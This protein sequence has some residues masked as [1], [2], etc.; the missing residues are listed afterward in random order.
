LDLSNKTLTLDKDKAEN[1][2]NEKWAKSHSINAKPDFGGLITLRAPTTLFDG[3]FLSVVH[4]SNGGSSVLTREVPESDSDAPE[5]VRNS[6]PNLWVVRSLESVTIPL[7][8][9]K[10]FVLSL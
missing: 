9:R 2:R 7:S 4:T 8:R 6:S 1:F 3:N 5:I 10:Q